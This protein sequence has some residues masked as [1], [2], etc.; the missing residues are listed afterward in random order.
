MLAALAALAAYGGSE[1]SIACDPPDRNLSELTVPDGCRLIAS[2]T[3]SEEDPIPF[4]GE[5]D[6]VSESRHRR[7]P[8]TGDDHPDAFGD[9]QIDG[10]LRRISVV[11]GDDISGERCELGEN[12]RLKSD[13]GTGNEGP[14]PTV[15]YEEG[16]RRITMISVR[17]PKEWDL[18]DPDWRVVTQMKQ[19]QPYTNPTLSSVFELQM[20]AGTWNVISN[21]SEPLWTAPAA[22]D[23]WTRFAFDVTYSQDPKRGLISVYADLNGDGDANDDGEQSGP[24]RHATLKT[25]RAGRN[26]DE[27]DLVPGDPIPSHLR[28]GLYQNPNFK[29]PAPKGCTVDIDNVQVIDAD[30]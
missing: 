18:Q 3:A 30:G 12:W 9:S 6:C 4:W 22:L 27:N 26:I 19:A 11:D 25:E 15:L 20:R 17:L 28:A 5:I 1:E 23:Q 21:W 13:P 24:I 7:L 16:D 8:V 10:G 29:C 2:D 14:G